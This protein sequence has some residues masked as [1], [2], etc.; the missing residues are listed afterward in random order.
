M[1]WW[2]GRNL[3][4]TETKILNSLGGSPGLMVMGD[5][6]WLKG[7]GFESSTLYW[8]ELTFLTLICCKNCIDVCLKRPKINEK[9]SGIGPFFKKNWIVRI[10]PNANKICLKLQSFG[11]FQAQIS[12]KTYFYVPYGLDS[13][14]QVW[15]KS[16]FSIFPLEKRFTTLNPSSLFS[17]LL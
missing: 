1:V 14:F 5:D 15:G 13:L 3:D 9:D 8:T 2:W 17:R 16:G 10:L 6:S 4:F 7:H 12:N 11:D